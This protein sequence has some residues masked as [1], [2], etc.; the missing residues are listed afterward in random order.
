MLADRSISFKF[1][2][3]LDYSESDMD[4]SF[5]KI[6]AKRAQEVAEGGGVNRS[7]KI[8]AATEKR[9]TEDDFFSHARFLQTNGPV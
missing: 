4:R 2:A 1:R 6:T 5:L 3:T 8:D 7:K 9:V